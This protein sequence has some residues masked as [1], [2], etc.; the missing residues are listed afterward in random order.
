MSF[1][2]LGRAGKGSFSLLG[3]TLA[4]SSP[5]FSLDLGEVAVG[6]GRNSSRGPGADRRHS[7]GTPGDYGYL[8]IPV[9][10]PNTVVK[11]VPPM[12]LLRA[13]K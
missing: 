5:L 3:Y 6:S 4:T 9:P 11:Q 8:A 10:I 1:R 12:I 7:N 13:R 2:T